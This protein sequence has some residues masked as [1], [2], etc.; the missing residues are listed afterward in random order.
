MTLLYSYSFPTSDLRDGPLLIE[1]GY[2]HK[3]IFAYVFCKL[4]ENHLDLNCDFP[5][6]GSNLVTL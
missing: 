5:A 6:L 3:R 2:A 4:L 1:G